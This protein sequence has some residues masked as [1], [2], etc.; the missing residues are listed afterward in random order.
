M[1]PTPNPLSTITLLSF[2]ILSFIIFMLMPS[3]IELK[4]PK[5]PGPRVIRDFDYVVLHD[6]E[7]K[8]SSVKDE[9]PADKMS[10]IENLAIK[11]VA[12]VLT[13]LPSIE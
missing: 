10:K 8:F 9:N 11:E 1:I 12:A 5:D 3:I 7:A 2:G 6:L 4:K 13:F